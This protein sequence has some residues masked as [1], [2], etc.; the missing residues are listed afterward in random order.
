MKTALVLYD[1][2]D[3]GFMNLLQ[4]H[5]TVR[6]QSAKSSGRSLERGLKAKSMRVFKQ[7]CKVTKVAL[8]K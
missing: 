4:G 7:R 3:I 6:T 2:T 8:L 5:P 1:L